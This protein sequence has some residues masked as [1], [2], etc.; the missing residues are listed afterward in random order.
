MA[1]Y[2]YVRKE[3]PVETIKQLQVLLTHNCDNVFVEEQAF[4]KEE[5]LKKMI[6]LLQ[7]QDTVVIFSL[8]V[9][10]KSQ[11]E[12]VPIVTLFLKR[13]VRLVSISDQIDSENQ[14]DFYSQLI[15]FAKFEQTIVTYQLKEVRQEGLAIATDEELEWGRPTI[16]SEKI[17]RIQFLYQNKNVT[18]REIAA[19]CD[20]SLGTVHKYVKALKTNKGE[21]PKR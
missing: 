20:V 18:F 21:K 4:S 6:D 17:K 7:P 3:F 8:L 19:E 9:F 1:I 13:D 2:A 15:R 12:L 14:P 10:G 16:T 11:Q 5:E